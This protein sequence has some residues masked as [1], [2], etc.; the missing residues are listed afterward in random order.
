MLAE[1][2]ALINDHRVEAA[3]LPER[4]RL[5]GEPKN[6]WPRASSRTEFSQQ[7][8]DEPMRLVER[9]HLHRL[10]VLEPDAILLA[11]NP[12][13]NLQDEDAEA[14]V[15][16]DEISLGKFSG[17]VPQLKGMPGEPPGGEDRRE[18]LVDFSLGWL[19]MRG[20]GSELRIL[21]DTAGDRP[22]QRRTLPVAWQE[23]SIREISH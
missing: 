16:D 20:R 13:L 23:I 7:D 21:I 14:R 6:S 3:A 2:L 17:R 1:V 8:P 10:L 18:R 12:A 4:A 15:G 5:R 9:R 22:F 19:G 11:D